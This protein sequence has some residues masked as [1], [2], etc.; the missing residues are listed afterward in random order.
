MCPTSY[1]ADVRLLPTISRFDAVY[2]PFFKAGGTHRRVQ[3]YPALDAWLR[4]CWA[5]DGVAAT[6]DLADAQASYYRQLF[7]LSPG[8]IVPTPP[9]PAEVGLESADLPE[10]NEDVFVLR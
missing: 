1:Q 2:A 3:D 9:T 7:P 5:L 8:N 6:L 4:R 10:V